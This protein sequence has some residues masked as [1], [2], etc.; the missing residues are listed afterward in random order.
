M[1]AIALQWVE[2]AEVLRCVGRGLWIAAALAPTLLLHLAW[3]TL[4]VASP[5]PRLFL[6]LAARALGVRVRVRSTGTPLRRDVF[7]VANHYPVTVHFLEP[8]DP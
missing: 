1:A 7:Y 5:W 3:Q 4:R 6:K 2:P 8:F